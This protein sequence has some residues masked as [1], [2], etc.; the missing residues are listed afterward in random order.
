M[1]LQPSC[2]F[3]ETH[4]IE[5]LLSQGR[6]K[7]IGFLPYGPMSRSYVFLVESSQNKILWDVL[8]SSDELLDILCNFGH[9]PQ[10]T[11]FI[12]LMTMAAWS[13]Y[14]TKGFLHHILVSQF[15]PCSS[16][17]FQLSSIAP[18]HI[19]HYLAIAFLKHLHGYWPLYHL[20]LPVARLLNYITPSSCAR[21]QPTQWQRD[22]TIIEWGDGDGLNSPSVMLLTPS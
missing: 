11:L 15:R 1:S 6:N 5:T 21:Y 18:S 2:H 14:K 7:G 8:R 13:T 3:L 10:R 12:S 22:A 16:H 4:E 9:H 20:Y 19:S 17:N